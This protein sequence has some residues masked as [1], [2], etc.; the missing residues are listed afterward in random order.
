[1]M[2]GVRG[3]ACHPPSDDGW[4]AQTGVKFDDPTGTEAGEVMAG[5]RRRSRGWK[6]KEGWL[7]AT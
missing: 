2:L 3:P 7:N 4:R 1:M 6:W 5:A